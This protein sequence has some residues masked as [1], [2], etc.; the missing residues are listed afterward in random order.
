M[1][2]NDRPNGCSSEIEGGF[3]EREAT[4]Q[5]LMTLGIQLHVP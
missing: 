4:P 2:G 3:V 1:P 5:L